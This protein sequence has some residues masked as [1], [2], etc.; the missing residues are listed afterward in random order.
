MGDGFD[1]SG[2]PWP[3]IIYGIFMIT[4]GILIYFFG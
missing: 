2:T 3:V 1:T 4:V